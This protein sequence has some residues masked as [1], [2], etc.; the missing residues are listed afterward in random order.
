MNSSPCGQTPLFNHNPCLQSRHVALCWRIPEFNRNPT[1]IQWWTG[2]S[3]SGA[4]MR[5]KTL[6]SLLCA[7]WDADCKCVSLFCKFQSWNELLCKRLGSICWEI[8]G[9]WSGPSMV[10]KCFNMRVGLKLRKRRKDSLKFLRIYSNTLLTVSGSRSVERER[11]VLRATFSV[12]E[13]WSHFQW[14]KVQ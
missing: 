3:L 4:P 11:N 10:Q 2:N 9:V 14:S 7:E 12:F 5:Q 13:V 6:S 8:S 1:L